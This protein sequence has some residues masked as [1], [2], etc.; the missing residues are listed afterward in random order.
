MNTKKYTEP[1]I[2]TSMHRTAKKKDA[3]S[4][5]GRRDLDQVMRDF[6]DR[7]DGLEEREHHERFLHGW[8]GGVP[9]IVKMQPGCF[10]RPSSDDLISAYESLRRMCI[11]PVTAYQLGVGDNLV[12]GWNVGLCTT[13]PA[14]RVDHGVRDWSRARDRLIISA[15]YPIIPA[16]S[17]QTLQAL[18]DRMY[19]VSLEEM[20]RELYDD[21]E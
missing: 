21:A 3:S 8:G 14:V 12:Q 11:D 13:G 18:S 7:L 4:R 9:Y 1:K 5:E 16:F 19:S 15:G 10:G 20:Q 6:S 17:E 2:K